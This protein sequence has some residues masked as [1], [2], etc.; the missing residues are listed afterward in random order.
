MDFGTTYSGNST[1]PLQP[2]VEIFEVQE[3]FKDYFLKKLLLKIICYL[4][5]TFLF[6]ITE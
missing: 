5:L 1:S 4:N 3:S 6:L 2:K